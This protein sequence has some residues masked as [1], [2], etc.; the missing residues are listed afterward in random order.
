M[1]AKLPHTSGYV[2]RD[3]LKLHYDVYGQGEHTIFFV[4]TW[5]FVHSRI[6]KAQVPYFSEY[7]RCIT[8][9]PRG[10]GKSDTPDSAAQFQLRD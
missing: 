1:R 7:F 2:D 3:G 6:W 4:P 10:N 8:M 9:D 5:T